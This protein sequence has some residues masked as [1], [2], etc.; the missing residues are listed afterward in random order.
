MFQDSDFGG[1]VSQENIYLDLTKNCD[2]LKRI[3]IRRAKDK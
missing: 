3:K 2:K 1:Y